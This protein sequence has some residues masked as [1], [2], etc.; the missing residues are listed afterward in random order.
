MKRI[1]T[2][3]F[4]MLTLSGVTQP[5][6]SAQT[7]E[8]GKPAPN[9]QLRT[10]DAQPSTA[11]VSANEATP[12]NAVL[13]DKA[14]GVTR[15]ALEVKTSDDLAREFIDSAVAAKVLDVG[16]GWNEDAQVFVAV[17]TAVFPAKNP[18]TERDF[19]T[20]RAQ[21]SLESALNAKRSI[22]EYV[23]VEMKAETLVQMPE[24]GL[25]TAFDRQ[26]QELDAAIAAATNEFRAALAEA[27][28]AR[29]AAIKGVTTT[30]VVREGI[31]AYIR[32]HLDES[33]LVSKLEQRK[34]ERL[35][36]ATEQL[37]LLQARIDSFKKESERLRSSLT[38][39]NKTTISTLASMHLVGAVMIAQFESWKDGQFSLTSVFTWSP[40]QEKE[41]RA[42]VAGRPVAGQPGGT[43]LGDYIRSTDWTT[44]IGGRKHLDDKGQGHI[45][46]IGAFPLT[47]S[48]SA[49]RRAAE[50][51][52]LR[53][54][55]ASVASALMA[56]I[57]ARSVAQLSMQERKGA[58]GEANTTEAQASLGERLQESIQVTLQG[59]QRRYGRATKHP[60][61][62]QDMF[63]IVVSASAAQAAHAKEMEKN[64]FAS[65]ASM[66]DELNRS[67]GIRQGLEEGSR[68]RARDAAPAE[69]GRAEG[70]TAMQPVTQQPAPAQ[71]VRQEP[72]AQR[73]APPVMQRDQSPP[74]EQSVTGG[75]SS[76]GAF[77]Y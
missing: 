1:I 25:G 46:G 73:P 59:V 9:P 3:A 7:V 32:K 53:L 4:M 50:L 39:E 66:R 77:R 65:A 60:I 55:Q 45:L 11:S 38:Q 31:A 61:S 70:R 19:L 44:A 21:K 67:Q 42:I 28:A 75:G 17:G 57:N 74:R 63:V 62:G 34:R 18:R 6:V 48:S 20:K 54:A 5:Q 41:V 64:L 72:A 58:D 40:K 16:E 10:S 35:E 56:D 49:E 22:I 37:N 12:L 15:V 2:C 27:D 13:H 26:T 33:F 71:N 36:R 8:F 52:A 23:R 76:V 68:Q 30:E 24:T 51:G 43:P 69:A 47:G 29:A 14:A